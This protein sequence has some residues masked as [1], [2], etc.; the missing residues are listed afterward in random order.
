M[1]ELCPTRDSCLHYP[2]QVELVKDGNVPTRIGTVTM[3]ETL[4]STHRTIIEKTSPSTS[5]TSKKEQ[6][7]I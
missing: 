4:S 5:S 2:A 7:E 6:E 1:W 3:S